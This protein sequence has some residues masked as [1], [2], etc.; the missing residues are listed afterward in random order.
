[1]HFFGEQNTAM[2]DWYVKV[3]GATRCRQQRMRR[4]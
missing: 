4:S 3:F 2:R 1:M